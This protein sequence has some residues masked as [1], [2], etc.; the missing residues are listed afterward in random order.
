AM[1]I[2]SSTANILSEARE[3]I[4]DFFDIY[5]DTAARTLNQDEMEYAMEISSAQTALAGR[6]AALEK[7]MRE[8]SRQSAQFPSAIAGNV[9]AARREMISAASSL[10]AGLPADS[11]AFQERALYQLK[12]AQKG[13]DDFEFNPQSEPGGSS[14]P[15]FF[16]SSGGKGDSPGQSSPGAGFKQYDFN[17]PRSLRPGY[18]AEGEIINDAMRGERPLKYQDMLKEYYEQLLK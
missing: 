13:M 17:I 10:K 14:M 11:L 12:K 15:S 4:R 8:Y 1:D 18:D 9:R 3:E 7:K 5:S 16:P 2:S 6:A